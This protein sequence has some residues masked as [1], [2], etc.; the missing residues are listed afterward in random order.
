MIG[1]YIMK[2]IFAGLLACL[3]LMCSLSACGNETQPS[4]ASASPTEN[5]KR[6][7]IVCTNFP[8]YDFVRQIVGDKADVTMLL[9]PGAESHTF[10]PTPKDIITI[11]NSDLFLYVGGDSDEWVN[12]ILDSMQGRLDICPRMI[13][14]AYEKQPN[15]SLLRVRRY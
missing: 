10:E 13:L 6:L 9:K 8:E 3:I 5:A 7:S 2:R 15:F 12:G 14:K 11:Q 1:D 4:A